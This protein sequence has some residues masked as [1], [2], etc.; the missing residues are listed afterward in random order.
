MGS[1][2]AHDASLIETLLDKDGDGNVID[3]VTGI[4]FGENKKGG[5]GLLDGM[6]GGK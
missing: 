1:S 6:L 4:I 3:D 5:R 2:R